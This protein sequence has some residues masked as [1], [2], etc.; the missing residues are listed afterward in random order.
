[1]WASNPI[2][3]MPDLGIPPNHEANDAHTHLSLV[4]PWLFP[5]SF[6]YY[7]YY[8]FFFIFFF[9]F[10]LFP[11][12]FFFYFLFLFFYLFIYFFYF[13]IINSI[14]PYPLYS[15]DVCLLTCDRGEPHGHIEV[16][17]RLSLSLFPASQGFETTFSGCALLKLFFCWLTLL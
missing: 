14:S 3:Q 15:A 2:R 10:F 12:L 4:F 11:F 6:Y 5:P 1:M 7:Y 8:F 9:L 17:A 16:H 13:A